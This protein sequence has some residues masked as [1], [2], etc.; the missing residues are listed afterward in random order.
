MKHHDSANPHR[1]ATAAAR[2]RSISM[3][4]VAG[5]VQLPFAILLWSAGL[6][7]FAGG[8]ASEAPAAAVPHAVAL[9]DVPRVDDPA[10][11]HRNLKTALLASSDVVAGRWQ[12]SAPAARSEAPAA[13]A[14]VSARLA[15]VVAALAVEAVPARPDGAP[16]V[17]DRV[18]AIADDP[19]GAPA[20]EV[21]ESAV[22]SDA[23][24][25]TKTTARRHSAVARAEHRAIKREARDLL[26]RADAD[27]VQ[28]AYDL[29]LEHLDTLDY[30]DPGYLGLLAMA[31]LATDRPREAALTYR[32]LV[33]RDP[34]NPRW[35]TGLAIANERLGLSDA[36]RESYAH[37]SRLSGPASALGRYAHGRATA[38]P[39][40]G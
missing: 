4:N 27:T 8:S 20:I 5:T 34:D 30:E 40:V 35:W 10:V 13:S 28:R 21:V 38:P 37:V 22:R 25:M 24:A 33:E 19:P 23:P 7:W 16:A 39:G 18:A 17:P 11:A 2:V 9:P 15:A 6:G 12:P 31:A 3:R 14:D 29:L 32:H 26:A 1:N 36:A